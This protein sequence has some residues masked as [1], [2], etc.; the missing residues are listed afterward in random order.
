MRAPTLLAIIAEGSSFP[1]ASGTNDAVRERLEVIRDFLAAGGEDHCDLSRVRVGR[2]TWAEV[3]KALGGR[4]A[5]LHGAAHVSREGPSAMTREKFL[6]SFGER[7]IKLNNGHFDHIRSK[8]VVTVTE[9]LGRNASEWNL[10]LADR[11][12]NLQAEVVSALGQAASPQL[13][14]IFD[15]RPIMSLGVAASSTRFHAHAETWQL[16][17]AGL[18]AWW[19]GPPGS[20]GLGGRDPCAALPRSQD[21]MLRSKEAVKLALCVQHVG[22]A[23]YFGNTMPH[24][25]CNLERFV[26]GVGA[27]GHAGDWPTIHY[28]ARANDT[29]EVRRSV[30]SEGDVDAVDAQGSTPLHQ[31]VA[32]GHLATVSLLVGAGASLRKRD[33]EG[34]HALISAAERGDLEVV[35]FLLDAGAPLRR[36]D[37]AGVQAVHWAALSGHSSV[38][39]LLLARRASPRARDKK[40]T[41][42]IHWAALESDASTVQFLIKRRGDVRV[43]ATSGTQAL[44]W[45]A[46][47]GHATIIDALLAA[48]A[49]PCPRDEQGS[50]PLH[51]AAAQDRLAAVLRL[52]SGR[53][54]VAGGA[55]SVQGGVSPLHAAVGMGHSGTARALLSARASMDDADP[56][57][58]LPVHLAAAGGHASVLLAL[59]ALRAD[60]SVASRDGARPAHLAAAAGQLGIIEALADLRA[61][62]A[63]RDALGRTPAMLAALH[64][65]ESSQRLLGQLSSS[66]GFGAEL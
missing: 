24:A 66:S 52:T 30:E 26:L 62:F 59:A 22:E 31:A 44:H 11:A 12:Y 17:I 13:F 20:A 6:D 14:R 43:A 37:T 50:M 3:S 35:R 33:R 8:E 2:R 25:T 45:A 48:K 34:K 51:F 65:Q 7:R 64:K 4:P 61:D 55:C 38:L 1:Q 41:E 27:Q 21:A 47:V 5:L 60:I 63:A 40:G 36:G 9:Y 29:A 23:I 58:R 54:D 32:G 53:T 16:L 57:G 49:D 42:P 46:G 18:K 19:I 10:F 39:S 28:A 15:A 56:A